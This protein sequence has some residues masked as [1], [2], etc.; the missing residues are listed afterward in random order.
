VFSIPAFRHSIPG[1]VFWVN[2]EDEFAEKIL[3][4]HQALKSQI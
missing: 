3:Q 4:A 1:F 2:L